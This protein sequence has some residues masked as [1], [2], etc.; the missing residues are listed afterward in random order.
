MK[1]PSTPS[2]KSSSVR[3]RSRAISASP[4]GSASQAV[5][6]TVSPTCVSSRTPLIAS[7]ESRCAVANLH[8]LRAVR[9]GGREVGRAR[10]P[11]P[12]ETQ[13][14]VQ[15][16]PQVGLVDRAGERH[17]IAEVPHRALAEA[18]EALRRPRLLP[19]S[20]GRDP[21]G[22]GEMVKGED[23]REAVLVAGGE[24]APVVL[25]RRAREL[26]LLG[27][28]ARPLEREAVRVQPEIGHQGDVVRVAVVV[29]AGIAGDLGVVRAGRVLEQPAVVVDVA[30]LDLVAAVAAPHRKPSGKLTC[31]T[32]IDQEIASASLGLELDRPLLESLGRRS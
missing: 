11:P 7:T 27:L 15:E 2:R 26:A 22:R 17:E 9:V 20:G 21:A 29:V 5:S 4:P 14:L 24:H 25:E 10:A 18:G 8:G 1:S 28:D 32:Y 31:L 19:A 6:A 13:H 16:R 23:R 3:A 12:R 30:A